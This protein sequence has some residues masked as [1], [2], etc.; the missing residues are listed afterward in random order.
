MATTSIHS[1]YST[2]VRAVTYYIN[3]EKTENGRYVSGFMCNSSS[4][5]QIVND[6][7]LFRQKGRA[8]KTLGKVIVQSF[9]VGEVTPDVA[10]AIGN[11]LANRL[12]GG[13]Y[14]YV[15]ATHLDK[16]HIHNHIYFNN[17]NMTSGKSFET[18]H[19]RGGGSW[20]KIRTLSD[21]LCKDY[22]LSVIENPEHGKGKSWY[23]WSQDRAGLSWKS[24]LKFAIDE[25]IMQSE[26]FEDFL[27]LCRE[28]NI[29]TVYTPQN[30]ITLKFRMQGQQ[31]FTRAKTLGWYYDE[32]QIRKRIAEYLLIK[33]GTVEN[34]NIKSRKIIDTDNMTGSLKHW[35]EIQN[36]KEAS[37]L[38]NILAEF[39]VDSKE[40]LEDK[41]IKTYSERMIL[42]SKLNNIQHEINSLSDSINALKKYK[43][44][45]PIYQEYK[46]QKNKK[47]FEEKYYSQL[48]A[49]AGARATLKANFPDK[50]PKE[51]E[52]LQKR[53]ELETQRNGLN[54]QYKDIIKKLKQLDYAR[55]VLTS[56]LQQ[57][58]PSKDK[59]NSIE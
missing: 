30:K 35:A 18:T 41:S 5:N 22:N 7:N 26:N 29:E 27:R 1:I 47:S 20:K 11:E 52:L 37:K 45:K 50:V 31:K 55:S 58:E 36:M 33:N 3:P 21:E 6:F 2:E 16:D 14:Q 4:A 43:Q 38:I 48:T 39:E 17:T 23:E 57:Q 25:M 40:Q 59:N 19:N 51:E 13:E 53:Q 42:V 46:Q 44:F 8:K 56:Y 54:L 12:L 15:V 34:K 24:K 9:A 49:F 28:K 10:F 32:P